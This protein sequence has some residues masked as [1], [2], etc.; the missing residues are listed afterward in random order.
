M[1]RPGVH[2]E[3]GNSALSTPVCLGV[4]PGGRTGARGT[5]AGLDGSKAD[6]MVKRCPSPVTGLAMPCYAGQ[7]QDE[8]DP[9]FELDWLKSAGL[10]E[11]SASPI[12]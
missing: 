5:G 8:T 12:S 4:P 2:P 7:T 9:T 10:L 6:I 1:P 11:K 3:P